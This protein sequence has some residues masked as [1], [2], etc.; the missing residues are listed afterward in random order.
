MIDLFKRM[1]S[2]KK[3]LSCCG[4][5]FPDPPQKTQYYYD[6]KNKRWLEVTPIKRLPYDL[7]LYRVKDEPDEDQVLVTCPDSYLLFDDTKIVP[8]EETWR[9]ELREKSEVDVRYGGDWFKGS[10]IWTKEDI[11]PGVLNINHRRENRWIGYFYLESRLLA[12]YLTHTPKLTEADLEKERKFDLLY[13]EQQKIIDSRIAEWNS[14]LSRWQHQ[15]YYAT[16]KNLF[17]FIDTR[18]VF[19]SFN[20]GEIPSILTE[21]QK[22]MVVGEEWNGLSTFQKCY[23][24]LAAYPDFEVVYIQTNGMP[25]EKK[26]TFKEADGFFNIKVQGASFAWLNVSDQF[27]SCD[28]IKLI[29]NSQGD[30]ELPGA[31]LETPLFKATAG[32]KLFIETD[33]TNVSYTMLIMSSQ[34]RKLW[35]SFKNDYAVSW[36]ADGNVVM[37]GNLWAP[38][39]MTR[40]EELIKFC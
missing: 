26:F 32:A 13:T 2:A 10:V 3:I 29:Q 37:A 22:K 5:I 34:T 8:E 12:P 40:E 25:A 18:F 33:G 11:I 4:A 36:L 7:C 27:E 17:H 1:F 39:L 31:T 35:V 19:K 28:P 9:N 21:E 16:Q 15:K 24:W 14:K 23:V 6:L 38:S 30:F 20:K